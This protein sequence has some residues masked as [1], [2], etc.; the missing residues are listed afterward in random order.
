MEHGLEPSVARDTPAYGLTETQYENIG[1][2]LAEGLK[3]AQ[4]ALARGHIEYIEPEVDEVL[5]IYRI[6]L[7]RATKSYRDLSAAVLAEHVK[8]LKAL[9][10]R[11]AGEPIETPRQPET[12]A[13]S[14][15]P[16]GDTLRGAFVAWK[17]ARKPS[18]GTLTEYERAITLFIELH[19]DMAVVNIKRS[20]ARQFREALQDVPRKRTGSLRG[21]ILPELAQWGREH[22]EV[23]RLSN[24]TVNKLLSGVQAISVFAR[25][26]G[27]IPD[28]V[29]WA[30]P[31]A[32]MQLKQDQPDRGPFTVAEL[33]LLFG[34]PVFTKGERPKGGKGD[35]AF[36]LPLL[37]LFTGARR[38]ELA[39]LTAA[40][41]H[42][43][44]TSGHPVIVLS[45]DQKRNRS[46]KTPGSARTIP[47]HPE[48]IRLGFMQFV[49]KVR[50]AQGD[51]AWLFPEIA[52]TTK[53]APARGRSGS[54]DTFVSMAWGTPVRCFT[55]CDIRSRM[56]CAL[57]RFLRT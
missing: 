45:E 5:D 13:R 27:L 35:V 49:E 53:A 41:A 2:G 52:P 11:H 31:F 26:Q 19:G 43:E 15:A 36:W 44:E 14:A 34:S 47:L 32:N 48:L 20:H 51:A 37:G 40:D 17:K 46:L 55:R 23:S 28:D 8:A 42:H 3:E 24:G 1:R 12:D 38:G 18:A 9:Q 6:R 30:D 50:R 56:L 54:A 33:K 22:P 16:A 4:G 39:G 7:D 57:P 10:L 21:A 29:A 25:D